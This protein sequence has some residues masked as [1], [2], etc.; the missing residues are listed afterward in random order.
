MG[1]PLQ[2]SLLM[3]RRKGLLHECNSSSASYLFQ[4][5]KFY[6]TSFD[7][8]DK[9][10]S[11]GRKVDAFKFWLMFK[12]HGESGF[13]AMIDNA[14][15]MASYLASQVESR[16]G[17]EL[18]ASPQYTNVCFYYVPVLLRDKTRDEV[19]WQHIARITVFV[20]EMMVRNGNLM[21]G[22]SPLA[23]RGLG[24]FF[25]MVV[26][27]LPSATHETMDFVLNEIEKIAEGFECC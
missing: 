9:S 16:Q 2:C 4:Q 20:K 11:C 27:C 24:N 21:I 19:W 12:K 7:T 8:G 10:L 14:F 6:D 17:F 15:A 13:G 23:S 18:I 26:T 3:V 1:V 25:R 5:D 22:Y